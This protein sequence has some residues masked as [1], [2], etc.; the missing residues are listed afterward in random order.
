MRQA[1]DTV[2]TV[3]AAAE[4][5]W[6]TAI[7]RLDPL[8]RRL[9]AVSVQAES[10]GAAGDEVAAIRRDLDTAREMV[11]T[12]VLTV[13]ATDALPDVERRIAALETRLSGLA[14]VRDEFTTRLT[15]LES[16]LSD[17]EAVEATA[18]QTYPAVL[19]KIAAPGLPVPGEQGSATVRARLRRLTD[20]YGSVGWDVLAREA[21]DL[22]RVATAA[23][24]GARTALRAITGLLDRRAEL[25]GR[26]EAYQVKAARLG[27]SEDAELTRLHGEAHQILFTAPCD[28]A[29]ATR[30][31]NRYRQ[32][33]QDRTQPREER[34]E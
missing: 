12:D 32:A 27:H 20:R 29:G 15:A 2:T 22:D 33:I 30:A 14:R 23:L 24:E 3:L 10:V 5:A 6:S 17:I 8:D 18:R 34:T 16:A 28:L 19:E 26:L 21:D 7:G 9:H 4:S 31:L 11:L 25:R 13:H 1:F